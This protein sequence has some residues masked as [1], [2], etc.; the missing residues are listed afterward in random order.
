MLTQAHYEQQC[1]VLKWGEESLMT[2]TKYERQLAD[3]SASF[4]AEGY[5]AFPTTS[6]NSL[7]ATFSATLH[8]ILIKLCIIVYE[9]PKGAR[10]DERTLSQ[11]AR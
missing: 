7:Q 2:G 9:S 3:V 1:K 4:T 8:E 11:N 10:H 5:F 6:L